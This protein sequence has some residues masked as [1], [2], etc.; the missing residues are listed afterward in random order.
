MYR[1]LRERGP[2]VRSRCTLKLK[3]CMYIPRRYAL[4]NAVTATAEM[5]CGVSGE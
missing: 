4:A 1:G 2:N 3:G 5:P